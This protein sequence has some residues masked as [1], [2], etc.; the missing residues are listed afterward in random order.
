MARTD[1]HQH[2]WPEALIA[3][4]ARRDR[5]PMLRRSGPAWRLTIAGE[6]EQEINLGGHDPEVRRSQL[7][8]DGVDRAVIA[9]SSPLGIESLVADEAAPLL[10][11]FHTGVLE[12]GAPFRAWGSIPLRSPDPA[13]VDRV[14]DRGLV[15]L[16]LPAGPLSSRGG[17]VRMRPVLD[18]LARRDAPLFIHPGP[19]PLAIAT[20]PSAPGDPAWWPALTR[21]VAEMSAAW[22]A[23]AAWGRLSHPDLRVVFAMLAGG[24]PLHAER[25]AARRGPAA[26]IHDLGFFYDTSSYGPRAVDAA[27]RAVGIDQLVYGSDRPMVEPLP[28]AMLGDAAADVM[29]NANPARLL[30]RA[31]AT[32]EAAA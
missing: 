21:Y 25:L 12:L 16:A 8:A 26:A 1:L 3:A 20:H 15:G 13:D 11:A 14:L 23:F 7:E 18:R 30:G 10:D 9:P 4:L 28:L 29:L 19:D 24:A 31:G 17:L 22:H 32:L 2:L 5:P 27:I 6:P